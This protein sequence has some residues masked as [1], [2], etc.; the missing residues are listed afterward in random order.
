MGDYPMFELTDDDGLTHEF[1]RKGNIARYVRGLSARIESVDMP[2]KPGVAHFDSRASRIVS[3]IAIESSDVRSDPRPPGPFGLILLEEHQHSQ[4]AWGLRG[5]EHW[6][7]IEGIRHDALDKLID[8]LWEWMTIDEDSFSAWHDHPPL[9]LSDPS[10]SLELNL[11]EEIEA[12]LRQAIADATDLAC[13]SLFGAFDDGRHME[14]A[15]ALGSMLEP[16]AVNMPSPS[17][18]RLPDGLELTHDWG[19]IPAQ[20]VA[21]WRRRPIPWPNYSTIEVATD[22]H[23]GQGAPRG[24]TGAVVE[25]HDSAYEIEIVDSDGRTEFLGAMEHEEV[26]FVATLSWRNPFK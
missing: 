8:H 15:A 4:A 16:Y 3:R 22:R 13:Y 14:V 17:E 2:W 6:L 24:A 20:V 11:D 19:P 1:A 18:Y 21:Q 9:L 5:F 7:Q 25:T 10:A 12:S 26:H 23:A